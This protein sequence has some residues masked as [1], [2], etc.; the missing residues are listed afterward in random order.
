MNEPILAVDF[1]TTHSVVGAW[2]D[3]K[4]AGP[5]PLDSHS[6]TPSLM[7][8]LLYFPHAESCY[9]GAE[10]L[11]NYVENDQE[12]R[13]FRSFKSHLPNANYLGTYIEDRPLPLEHMVGLFL[14]ELR[15][16]AE[17][18]TGERFRKVVLGRPARY[19]M[20][21][22]KEGIASH[23]MKKAAEYAGFE[24]VLFF[25]EPVAAALDYKRRLTGEQLVLI[26]DFGG[27]TSDFTILKLGDHDYRF[28]D[29]LAI[30]G[31][32]VAGDALDGAIMKEKISL[33]FGAKVKY[34][35]PMGTNILTMPPSVS[36]KLTQPAWITHLR[37]KDTLD[38]I[39]QVRQ[40]ALST[41]DRKKMDQ[42]FVL[43]EDQLIFSVFDKI[44]GTKVALSRDTQAEFSMAYPGIEVR[45]QISRT[46][47]E[48][49]A[50]PSFQT[51]FKTL[52]R[53]FTA[54]SLSESQ[55]SA[56]CLTGGTSRVPRITQALENRFGP[57]RI[58]TTDAF[59][60]VLSGL[61]E[62]ARLWSQDQTVSGGWQ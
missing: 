4:I 44:E 56:L 40:C 34:R 22:I 58:Q 17:A 45:E 54:C 46:D 11:K 36:D 14:L 12:G 50:E 55:I 62:A 1:G 38:F 42:L 30:D 15:K 23:R 3:G 59:H 51:I 9:Y 2:I 43:L 6:P 33:H 24:E 29:V 41:E 32:S 26:G 48:G 49:W 53:L 47:F 25:A 5:L 16:R 39:G 21:P 52:D 20:D 35:L 27:G 8:T 61:I 31:C 28:E 37:E 19:S 60:S 18:V 57:H 7:R 13:L 10:A